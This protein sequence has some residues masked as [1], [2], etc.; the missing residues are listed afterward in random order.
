MERC[1]RL[2]WS[3]FHKLSVQSIRVD[4]SKQ[5]AHWAVMVFDRRRK[6]TNFHDSF[7]RIIFKVSPSFKIQ[8]N[9]Y[10][11]F[12]CLTIQNSLGI[13]EIATIFFTVRMYL[14]YPAWQRFFLRLKR[15]KGNP[16][17]FQRWKKPQPSRV[18]LRRIWT[19]K[20]LTVSKVK[21]YAIHIFFVTG[22]YYRKI[23]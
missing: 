18:Y 8:F 16:F 13:L 14:R 11:L 15:N 21:K 7:S 1:Q 17:P 22:N 12:L 5:S 3:Y 19:I 20:V 23:M 2:F 9:E 4:S 10:N 6:L